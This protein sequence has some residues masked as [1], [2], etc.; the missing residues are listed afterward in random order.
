MAMADASGGKR[1]THDGNKEDR[2]KRVV[3]TKSSRPTGAYYC[4][5]RKLFGRRTFFRP[6]QQEFAENCRKLQE[7]ASSLVVAI[8]I[9]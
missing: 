4:A 7:E 9:C 6:M 2:Q 5:L 3:G 8:I 1:L